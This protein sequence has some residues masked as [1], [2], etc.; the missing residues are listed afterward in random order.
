[1]FDTRECDW[2]LVRNRISNWQE[3][4]MER[5]S[6]EYIDL[7]SGDENAFDKFWKLKG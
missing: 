4:Y 2:K 1:M 6:R 7:L 5:L 3:T